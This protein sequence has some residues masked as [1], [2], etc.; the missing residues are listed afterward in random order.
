MSTRNETFTQDEVFADF[1]SETQTET[2]KRKRSSTPS[3]KEVANLLKQLYS[4]NL[5]GPRHFYAQDENGIPLAK[6]PTT[7]GDKQHFCAL[8]TANQLDPKDWQGQQKQRGFKGKHWPPTDTADLVGN[9][10][11]LEAC[12]KHPKDV[13]EC[14]CTY[15]SW[16]KKMH[17]FWL[18]SVLLR[19]ADNKG[20]GIY[21]WKPIPK[22]AAIGEYTGMLRPRRDY[23]KGSK[24]EHPGA[25]HASIAM[26]RFHAD[27]HQQVTAHIDATHVGSVVRFANH[28]CEANAKFF[29]GRCGMNN[30]ILFVEATHDIAAGEEITLDYGSQWFNDPEQPCRCGAK[31]CKNPP[32]APIQE[33]NADVEMSD[34]VSSSLTS[35]QSGSDE[36][37]TSGEA[38]EEPTKKKQRR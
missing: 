32:R 28:S 6:V 3:K 29:E 37:Y 22:E 19:D 18:E 5:E 34:S 27:V 16:Q 38:D 12:I 26:G 8:S 9:P 17:N 20:Y 13:R 24:T 33:E 31:K 7:V 23:K 14:K 25:Y 21:A 35:V 10:S 1:V 30:R 36:G 4:D 15:E 2:R 11:I